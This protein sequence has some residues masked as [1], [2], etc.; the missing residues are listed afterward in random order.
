MFDLLAAILKELFVPKNS[1]SQTRRR[2]RPPSRAMTR[3][4]SP[5][6]VAQSPQLSFEDMLR[7]FFGQEEEEDADEVATVQAVPAPVPQPPPP[8]EPTYK[9][10]V[11]TPAIEEPPRSA[12]RIAPTPNLAEKLPS[13][14]AV[15]EFV[16][17]LRANP[18][19]AREAFVYAEIFGPPLA[20]RQ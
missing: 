11:R 19:A 5:G 17:R 2:V 9:N 20:D 1:P 12:A 6:P 8:V 7:R 10:V 13:A 15:P 14:Q 18:A 3:R 4:Q 16:L